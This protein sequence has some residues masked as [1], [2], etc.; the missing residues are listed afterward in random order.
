M[1]LAPKLLPIAVAAMIA[2]S[3]AT[4]A[5]AAT[6]DLTDPSAV[7]NNDF[8]QFVNRKDAPG[9][10]SMSP[11][12]RSGSATHSTLT[13]NPAVSE[14]PSFQLGS[15]VEEHKGVRDGYTVLADSTEEAT[16]FVR[17]DAAGATVITAV[18]DQDSTN[19]LEFSLEDGVASAAKTATETPFVFL[20]NGE[21]A[22]LRAPMVKDADGKS[23][24][25]HYEVDGDEVRIRVDKAQAS[26]A[27]YPLVAASGFEYLMDFDTRATGPYK[28]QQEM[29]KTGQ[30]TKIF[31]VP[32]APADFPKKGGLLLLKNA[33]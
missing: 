9:D 18:G 14:V 16:Q 26:E 20:D 30:F 28:A 2:P 21:Q 27:A 32:G 11:T 23:L 15:S 7:L 19:D 6:I 13:V 25:A 31:P 5:T 3:I 10:V 22:A 8:S 17:A 33:F 29:H 12:F 4:P 24:N 1:K